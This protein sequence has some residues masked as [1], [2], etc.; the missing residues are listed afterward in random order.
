MSHETTKPVSFIFSQ[1]VLIAGPVLY[2]FFGMDRTER[3]AGFFNS[4]Q[5]VEMLIKRIEELA[6]GKER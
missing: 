4:R 5:N 2:P 6:E 1:A 3:F